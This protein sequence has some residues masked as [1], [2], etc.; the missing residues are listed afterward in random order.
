MFMKL[1]R[2]HP[3]GADRAAVGGLRRRGA[4]GLCCRGRWQCSVLPPTPVALAAL[5]IRVFLRLMTLHGRMEA[6]G[7][8]VLGWIQTCKIFRPSEHVDASLRS[9]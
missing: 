3:A 7:V 1:D 6:A 2:L 9:K 5:E 8:L 4:G